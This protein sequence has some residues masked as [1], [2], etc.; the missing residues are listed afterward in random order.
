MATVECG[1]GGSSMCTYKNG[2]DQHNSDGGPDIIHSDVREY[3][4]L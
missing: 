4:M 3:Q 2:I 1:G